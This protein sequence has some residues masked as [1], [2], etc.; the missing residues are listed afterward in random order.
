MQMGFPF[1]SLHLRTKSRFCF[2]VLE[3]RLFV[4]L[5]PHFYFMKVPKDI[6]LILT[7]AFWDS[8]DSEWSTVSFF[9]GVPRYQQ[10]QIFL[11]STPFQ[12]LLLGSHPSGRT[13]TPVQSIKPPNIIQSIKRC[14]L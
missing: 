1:L 14:P 6:I 11:I 4:L 12:F 2:E 13:L 3:E 8:R 9:H 5:W 7:L 10:R